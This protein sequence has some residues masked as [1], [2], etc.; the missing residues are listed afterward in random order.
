MRA[1]VG[2]TAGIDEHEVNLLFLGDGV[3]NALRDM[4]EKENEGYLS[5]LDEAGVKYYVVSEDLR[6]RGIDEKELRDRFEVIDRERALSLLKE[7]DMN[8]DW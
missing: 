8:S 6:E 2:A 1:A 3:Y 4:E 5:T 7:A